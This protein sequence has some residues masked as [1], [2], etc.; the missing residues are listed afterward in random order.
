MCCHEQIFNNYR[1]YSRLTTFG[2]TDR[3][4]CL[5]TVRCPI[6]KGMSVMKLFVSVVLLLILTVSAT[7]H[8]SPVETWKCWDLFDQSESILVT[9]TVE[10]GRKKGGIAVAG[11][12]HAT[13]FQVAGFDRR[14]DFGSSNKG[15]QYSFII[16]P[17][18]DG[19]YFDFGKESKAKPSKLM[20]CREIGAA[21]APN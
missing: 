20:K 7:A 21:N 5:I 10:P 8:A 4:A 14:W 19:H 16:E 6:V 2:S 3:C 11:V 1:K 15:Y 13:V 9:A 12:I 17:N 18:G